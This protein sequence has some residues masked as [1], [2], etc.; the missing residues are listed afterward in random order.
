MTVLRGFAITI[1]SG[2]VFAVLGAV[3]GFTLGRI[4][5]DYY[6]TVFR[7]PPG[8]A[9]DVGQTGLGLGMTQGLAAGLVIVVTVAW[10]E[11]RKTAA[12]SSE[13]QRVEVP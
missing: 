1:G 11:S 10:S 5:P 2:L 3:L 9:L 12:A 6:R 8:V 7:M 13:P 4:A